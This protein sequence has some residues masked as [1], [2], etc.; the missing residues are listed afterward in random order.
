MGAAPAGVVPALDGRGAVY[1]H[2]PRSGAWVEPARGV[3]M[4]KQH[5]MEFWRKRV[6]AAHNAA[7]LP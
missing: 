4:L 1:V 3:E 6:G 7:P 5:H 2:D